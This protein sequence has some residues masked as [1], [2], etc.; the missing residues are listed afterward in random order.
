MT[1]HCNHASMSRTSRKSCFPALTGTAKKISVALLLAGCS[2]SPDAQA[3][4]PSTIRDSSGVA[5]VENH[6]STATPVCEVAPEPSL[7]IGDMNGPAEYQLFRTFG[8]RR[9]S[10]GRIAVVNQGSQQLRFYDAEGRF[11]TA[12]GRAGDGPGE[13]RS[14]FTLN[15]LPGDTL[16]VGD[17]HPWQWEIF[18]P[19]GTWV[20]SLRPEPPH[21]NSEAY[22]VLEDGRVL[23]AEASRDQYP[24]GEFHVRKM[25]VTLHDRD[26]A[27][28]D[29]IGTFE[30]QRQGG[31]DDL[32]Y[33][34]V[35][36]M[37]DPSSR[38]VTAG[39]RIITAHTSLPELR[40][41]EAE[42]PLRLVR[43][44][45]WIAEERPVTRPMIEAERDRISRL[46]PDAEEA[47]R[48]QMIYLQVRE[49]R[50]VAENLPYFS[51]LV[52]GRDGR[53]W[54][55]DYKAPID[56]GLDEWL[57]FDPEG[58]LQCRVEVFAF[59][60]MPEFGSDYILV[61][62]RDELGV[63]RIF[64]HKLSGPLSAQGDA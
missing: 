55:R 32:P 4:L 29:T 27:L 8:A 30:M 14:A 53:I 40:V 44:I 17:M 52:V 21:I 16:W 42:D 58:A 19:D 3:T 18:A 60:Q 45:R 56:S 1:Q 10:D 39:N 5:I 59:E 36:G 15:V 20:R 63:E 34:S 13:F 57:V 31:F 62:K 47:D 33:F 41:Y 11:L 54:V 49:D 28:V 12:S 37:F 26:G 50:P 2:G 64:L 38:V 61:M 46:Y 23:I 51:V 9:L 35:S 43:I 22:N 25:T 24:S 7:V 48:R 6:P